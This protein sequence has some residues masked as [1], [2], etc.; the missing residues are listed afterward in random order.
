[1]RSPTLATVA[2]VVAFGAG[3]AI[4]RASSKVTYFPAAQ[5]SASF[6]KGAVLLNNGSYQVHTSRRETPGQ[7][8][9][10]GK[11]TDIIYMLA[12]S[13]TFVTGGTMIGGKTT[14]P[15]EIRGSNIDG[16]ET[17]T[18]TKGDVMV[19]PSGTPHWFKEVA[20]PVLYYVVKVQ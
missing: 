13:T 1:M 11:D 3:L 20:G 6:D 17:R 7:V 16:G 10:H 8:E 4:P 15:D 18:L 12:G 2:I 14:A 19:V 9:V 5:V